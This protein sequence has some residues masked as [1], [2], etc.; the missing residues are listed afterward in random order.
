MQADT[1][2]RSRAGPNSVAD[3]SKEGAEKSHP[4]VGV[5]A[6]YY[7]GGPPSFYTMLF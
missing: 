2:V 4:G 5:F 7:L 3:G 6:I 1:W